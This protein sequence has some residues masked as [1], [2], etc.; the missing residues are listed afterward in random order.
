MIKI[1]VT[2]EMKSQY[3]TAAPYPHIVIDGFLPAGIL[4][5]VIEEFGR[6]HAW[7]HD[8]SA[9][10]ATH[11]QKKFFSPWCDDNIK[12]IPPITRTVLNY[13]NSPETLNFL[14]DLTGIPELIADTTF[15]GGGMHR[16]DSGG[17][18][19]VHADSN[20]HS[21]TGLYRRINLLLYLNRNW[22]PA[23][24]G[25]LQLWNNDMTKLVVNVEPIFNR[26]V[27]FNVNDDAYHGHPDLLNTPE[28][29]SRYSLALYYYTKDRPEHEKSGV[30]SA[31]W[32]ERPV[33]DKSSV[34]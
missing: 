34:A 24:G 14:Q 17:K 22:D 4:E 13:L 8:P 6:Y 25:E 31:V 19:S 27:I 12:D 23:W 20:T 11:Q 29:V 28:G 30:T 33:Q 32:K 5:R 9:Y 7:G 21:T 18:L 26:A 2:E 1:G 15:L 16:I 3:S 10:S